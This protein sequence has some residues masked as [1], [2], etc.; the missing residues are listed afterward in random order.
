MMSS[1]PASTI[2][3]RENQRV[4]AVFVSACQ[5]ISPIIAGNDK[6]KTMSNFAIAHMVQEHFPDLT[7]PEIYIIIATAEKMHKE[8]RLYAILHPKG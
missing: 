2:E 5:L 4:R 1:L 7:T 6:I 8:E 3:R